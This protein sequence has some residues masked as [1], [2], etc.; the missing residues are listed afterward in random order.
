[1]CLFFSL[2]EIFT[3]TL[4]PGNSGIHPFAYLTMAI[5]TL[6]ATLVNA[7]IITIFVSLKTIS[8]KE[9]FEDTYKGDTCYD[10]SLWNTDAYDDCNDGF[11]DHE[12][13]YVALA[14]LGWLLWLIHCALT[15]YKTPT[16]V[17][18]RRKQRREA[19]ALGGV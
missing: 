9:E 11:Y 6:L 14:V 7:L 10:R 17:R 16:D 5:I 15:C 12:A 18:A 1:M 13:Y 8:D 19:R 2:S 4:R 3:R